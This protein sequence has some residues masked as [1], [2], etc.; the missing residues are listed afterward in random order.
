MDTAMNNNNASTSAVISCKS[1]LS[2]DFITSDGVIVD[3]TAPGQVGVFRNLKKL[4]AV[5]ALVVSK[6][7]GQAGQLFYLS[8]ESA[9]LTGWALKPLMNGGNYGLCMMPKKF[10]RPPIFGLPKRMPMPS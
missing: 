1:V 9:S 10:G 5:E 3:G 8:H 4:R 2:E 7:S 6:I